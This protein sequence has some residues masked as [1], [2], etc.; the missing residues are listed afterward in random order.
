MATGYPLETLPKISVEFL[1]N[2]IEDIDGD[3]SAAFVEGTD[4][5]KKLV[6]KIDL[7]LMSTIWILYLFSYM[8]RS[9]FIS[10]RSVLAKH[11]RIVRISATQGSQE[12]EPIFH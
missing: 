9:C 1:E 7:Y 5:E 3:D 11:S 4:A 2:P 6:R 10:A 12:W 8:V